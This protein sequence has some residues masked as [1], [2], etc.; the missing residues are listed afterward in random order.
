RLD[1]EGVEAKRVLRAASVFGERFSRAGVAALLG[2]EAELGDVSDAIERL[3]ARELVARASAPEGHLDQVEFAF[4]HALVREAAY[5]MLT[6]EDRALGHRLA[7]AWLEHAG[8]GDPMA[9]AEH[10]RR[11]GEPA[12][13]VRWYE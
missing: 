12:R 11:G 8:G 2:G 10:F 4:A 5:A 6:D 13:A 1:A 9:L 3:A 7:G